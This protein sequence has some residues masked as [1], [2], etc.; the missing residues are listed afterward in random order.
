MG[1]T[2]NS[3]RMTR[4]RFPPRSRSNSVF[5]P[6]ALRRMDPISLGETETGVVSLLAP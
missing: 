1:S 5:S 2:W 4:R 6:V 3:L